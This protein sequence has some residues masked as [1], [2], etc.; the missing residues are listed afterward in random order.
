MKG[1][2]A[3]AERFTFKSH[4]L[5]G[6]VVLLPISLLLLVLVW[7]YSI[8][9]NI[10]SPYVTFY[11]APGIVEVAAVLALLVLVLFLVGVSARTKPGRWT[12]LNLERHV[13]SYL[14]GYRTI[15]QILEPFI[16]KSFTK[17][18]KSVALVD[19]WDN[20]MLMTAFVTDRAKGYIT[21]FVPT[22][23]NP[24]S[25]NIYHVPDKRVRFIDAKVD[26]VLTS[27]ISV[28]AGSHKLIERLK[29]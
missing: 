23:P 6:I 28:G 12:I 21:V 13:F 5:T 15:K 10:I 3:V 7:L 14:P 25:G 18:F 26:T 8:L 16:G 22:G 24:T 29:K 20:G 1:R 19:L 9:D 11:D 17:S 2:K 4:L 27:V